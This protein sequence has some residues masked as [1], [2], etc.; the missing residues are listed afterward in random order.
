M[1]RHL[2]IFREGGDPWYMIGIMLYNRMI[3]F[4]LYA[5]RKRRPAYYYYGKEQ[6]QYCVNEESITHPNFFLGLSFKVNTE[7]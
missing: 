5:S 4:T 6:F 7:S 3:K 2:G 1:N